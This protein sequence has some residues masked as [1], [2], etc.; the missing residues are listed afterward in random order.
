[1]SGKPDKTGTTNSAPIRRSGCRKIFLGFLAL[2][3][4]VALGA[5]A[6][7]VVG[8]LAYQQVVTP[9]APGEKIEVTVP[10]GAYGDEVA[11]ILADQGLIEHELLFRIA[12]RVDP[13]RKPIRQ[14]RYAVP[15][16]LSALEILKILQEGQPLPLAPDEVPDELKVTIPEGLTIAQ[17][18]ALFDEP[19]A[20]VAAASDPELIARVGVDVQTLEGFMMPNTYFF[21]RK[22]TEREVVERM[23]DQF[24]VEYN[25][26]L[27]EA[28]L[29][30]N[31]NKLQIVT[32]ASLVEEEARVEEERPRVAAVVYNRLKRRMPLQFDS[33]LQYALGKYGQR[34]LYE[35]RNVDSPYNTYKNPG[36]PPGPISTPGASALRAAMQPADVDYLFFVSNADGK[37]HTF[38]ST[39]AEHLKAVERFRREIAPQRREQRSP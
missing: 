7:G 32:V 36:L 15:K 18:A 23:V 34:L 19:D 9:G 4:V 33:T 12:M 35:D 24:E 1:M 10:S 22:P 39:E 26:I 29:P 16:G 31:Y 2:F 14:G 38:S 25:R 13:S 37:T 28:T 11:R 20:F 27:A 6:V 17:M 21:D 3:T 30:A 8:F 5:V